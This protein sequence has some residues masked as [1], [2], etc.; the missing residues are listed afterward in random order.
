MRSRL[1]VLAVLLALGGC[2]TNWGGDPWGGPGDDDDLFGDDDDTTSDDDDSTS[3]DDDSTT[4]DGDL[5]DDTIADEDEGAGDQDGDGVPNAEDTDSDGD[6]IPDSVEAGDAD[7]NTPPVDSDGDT[8]PDFL[9]GDSDDDGVSDELE[10]ADDPDGDG[11]PSYLDPD[12]DGDGIP[13]ADEIG[14]DPANPLDS[15]GDGFYDFEDADSDNDGIDDNDEPSYGTDPFDRD[16]DGD[17]FTDLAEA[18]A[19]TS[20]T[21]ASSVIEGYY[22]ELTPRADTTLAVP[23]TPEII[24]AD[25]LFVLDSTCSMTEELQTM[26]TN[27][28]QV[29]STIGIPDVAFGVAEFQD[30]A[31][32]PY[33]F[34][35]FNDKPFTLNQQITSS[36]GLVQQALNG[37]TPILHDGGD[38]PEASLEALYQALTGAGFDQDGDGI[39]DANPGTAQNTDVPPFIAS[40][41]DAFGGA[42]TGVNAPGTPG[43]GFLGGAGF[44]AGSVPVVVYTTDNYMRDPDQP[45]TYP[46]PTTGTP[47]AG[48]SDVVAAAGALGAKFIGIGTD[49]TPEPQMTA[50]ANQ[51]GSLADLDGNGTVE[52][53]V[54]VG[55]DGQVTTFVIDG[56]E[57][58]T[59]SGQFDLT[60]EIDDGPFDF[61]V[62]IQP[63]LAPAVTLGT[64]VTFSVTLYPGVPLIPQDQVFVF[65][66]QIVSDGGSV[67][68]EW[69]LVLVV[70]A[71][72]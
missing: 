27:F 19:G 55:L 49:V 46:T 63:A 26:A 33:G 66:M 59:D 36:T 13:D 44:R 21:D 10:G 7:V 52:P 12:A 50:L 56:I 57:A 64:T 25:V 30:Y 28:S 5:D 62:D 61:V 39:L 11:V 15:D 45:G 29:V 47:A 54:F 58:L 2:R 17:G 16:T 3:D 67:L 34:W 53:M 68:A 35:W 22:A 42:A 40:T 18:A 14:D 41:T 72:A 51:S 69:E 20:P 9:D 32:D 48:M 65:P 31:Q 6:G 71:G 24:Q 23:F 37:L 1:L 8:I 4:S 70:V 38:P 60:L 43:T